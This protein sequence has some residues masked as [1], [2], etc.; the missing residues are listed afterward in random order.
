M[1]SR[2]ATDDVHAVPALTATI[3]A[4]RDPARARIDA[5]DVVRG[6]IMARR[7]FGTGLNIL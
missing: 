3:D 4:S 2:P 1:L 6:A 7:L 5:I